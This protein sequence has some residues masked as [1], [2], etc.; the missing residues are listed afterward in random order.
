MALKGSSEVEAPRL[1]SLATPPPSRL[2]T[3]ATSSKLEPLEIRPKLDVLVAS[4][5]LEPFPLV[6]SS[7]L[8]V[9]STGLELTVASAMLEVPMSSPGR[10]DSPG[11][12]ELAS[13]KL[14]FRMETI[15]VP[16]LVLTFQKQV[17]MREKG[18]PQKI[19]FQSIFRW[20]NGPRLL[21]RLKLK[22]L[23]LKC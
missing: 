15:G 13:S 8:E 16:N 10:D 1:V 12:E 14:F 3:P 22:I 23:R 5:K 19:L 9:A 18:P 4:P 7:K 11:S 20:N 6:T 21:A 17:L 2:E